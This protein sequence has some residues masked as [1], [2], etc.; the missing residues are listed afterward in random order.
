[1]MRGPMMRS[2]RDK[3][4]LTISKRMGSPFNVILISL[5][6]SNW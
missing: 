4:E 5:P 6:E 2:A 3:G 1:M